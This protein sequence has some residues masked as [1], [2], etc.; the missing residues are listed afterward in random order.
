MWL[1]LLG[2]LI[3][4]LVSAVEKLFGKG[5]GPTKLDVVLKQL[6]DIINALATA[7]KLG[8]AAPTPADIIAQINKVAGQLFPAGTT[9][10][11]NAPLVPTSTSLDAATKASIKQLI[12]WALQ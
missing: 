1:T 10:A 2:P 9:V 12:L 4:V 8:G 6:Q 11:P 7:G 3:P 5:T